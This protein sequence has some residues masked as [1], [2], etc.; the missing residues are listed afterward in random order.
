MLSATAANIVAVCVFAAAAVVVAVV[1][2]VLYRRFH[3]TPAQAPLMAFSYV[4]CRM[5]WR[6]RVEGHFPLPDGQGAVIISN[7]RGPIDPAFIALTVKRM[8]HWMVAK[9]YCVLPGLRWFFRVLEVIP[10]GRG[11]IDTAATR[12]AIRIVRQGG[13]LGLFPEGRINTTDQMMLPGRPGAA[14]IALRAR[15]PVVPCYVT[16]S[17]D[18]GTFWGFLFIPAKVRLIM[19]EPIDLSAYYGRE[20]DREV[21]ED[22]TK[23]FLVEIAKLGGQPD[24]EPKVA[25]RFY[26]PGMTEE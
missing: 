18:D 16:G 1:A 9:E 2:V 24:F 7:H 10:V 21:L 17:P 3:Y 20:N 14:L 13:L 8:V 25:G 5:L 22:L 12:Q 6:A 23:R 26:K 11:G 15:A 4:M 19:G